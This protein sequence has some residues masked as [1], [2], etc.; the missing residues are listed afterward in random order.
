MKLFTKFYLITLLCFFIMAA[1]D[2]VADDSHYTDDGDLEDPIYSV[3]K[4]END[5]SMYLKCV[6]RAGYKDVLNSSGYYTVFA[7]S[8]EAF[9]IYLT[10]KGYGSVDDIPEADVKKLVQYSIVFTAFTEETIDDAFNY[11]GE[12]QENDAFRRKTLN[13]KGVFTENVDELGGSVNVVDIN[14]VV[15]QDNIG[16]TPIL[17]TNDNNYKW[18]PIFTSNYL[19]ANNVLESDYLNFFPNSTFSGF[20]VSGAKVVNSDIQCENGYVQTVD[21]VIEP[22]RNLLDIIE[23]KSEYSTFAGILEKYLVNY[24]IS[25]DEFIANYNDYNGTTGNIYTKSYPNLKF[26]PNTE[27]IDPS[28]SVGEDQTTTLTAFV[29]NNEAIQQFFDEKFLK[30]YNSLD[31]MSDELIADFI[32]SHLFTNGIWPSKFETWETKFTSSDIEESEMGSNGLFYGTNRVQESD[33]FFTVWGEINLNPAYSL[34]KQACEDNKFNYTLMSS[35]IWTVFLVDN[36]MMQEYGFTYDT[37]RSEWS[38]QGTTTNASSYLTRWLGLHIKLGELGELYDGRM[39]QSYGTD[40]EG[41]Y[42]KY[43]G[44]KFYASGN[45]EQGIGAEATNQDSEPNNGVTY[46]LNSSSLFFTPNDPITLLLSYSDYSLYCQYLM[47][48]KD[49][50]TVDADDPNAGT[51]E[52]LSGGAPNTMFVLNNDVMQSAIDA[53]LL[54]ANPSTS[55]VKEQSLVK[56]FFQYHIIPNYYFPYKNELSTDK[57]TTGYKD[58]DGTTEITI[59]ADE[60]GNRFITDGSSNNVLFSGDSNRV[61]I[62][63]NRVIIHE[64]QGYLNYNK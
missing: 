8:D 56:S 3:L 31:E 26:G 4:D 62:L 46:K 36:D 29:P 44:G 25:P 5:F 53:G 63:S 64:L 42:I 60:N 37:D 2:D 23:S 41:E 35:T 12:V 33:Y 28:S 57:Y 40:G 51:I 19:N 58:E 24:R 52:I 55:S 6:D 7:P 47:A 10:E 14:W 32:N 50:F 61:N 20:N 9:S 39:I 16:A 17:V 1:C 43:E 45:F 30:W 49:L 48:N 11:D 27:T 38:Y 13:Y 34:F 59:N 15:S 22:L 18:I 21:K 54:P